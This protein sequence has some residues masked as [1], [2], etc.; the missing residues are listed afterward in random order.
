MATSYLQLDKIS[1]LAGRNFVLGGQSY[2]PGDEVP[3]AHSYNKLEALVRGRFLIPVVDD[4]NDIPK[5]YWKQVRQRDFAIF[6]LKLDVH[7][8]ELSPYDALESKPSEPSEAGFDPGEHTVYDVLV[9]VDA[10]PEQA[11]DILEAEQAGKNRVTLV[12]ALE[13][14]LTTPEEENG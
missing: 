3:D 14:R 2:K 9:H 13:E 5:E 7:T 10:Y 11:A 1:F 6:K 12:T 4:L 8:P